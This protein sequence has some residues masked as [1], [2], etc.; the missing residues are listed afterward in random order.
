MRI[1]LASRLLS[2]TILSLLLIPSFAFAQTPVSAE[3]QELL[4][5]VVGE[6]E[7]AVFN[8]DTER[9][10]NGM[11]EELV[12]EIGTT[13]ES[14]LSPTVDI[15]DFS[16]YGFEFSQVDETHFRIDGKY[17]IES[18]GSNGTWSVN[19]LSTYIV[20]EDTGESFVISDTDLHEAVS[21]IDIRGFIGDNMRYIL[22]ALS[23]GFVFSAFWAWMLVDAIMRN[24]PNKAP[25]ILLIVLASW[26]GA[27]IYFFTG[28]KQFKMKK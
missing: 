8:Q 28:R 17:S 4:T 1:T 5:D 15:E 3:Y 6:I 12:A 7:L 22:L 16:I 9:L 23:L 2:S 26:L 20:L 13:I 24:I 25:W 27:V 10:L 21:P 11:T 19:G 18:R 14:A